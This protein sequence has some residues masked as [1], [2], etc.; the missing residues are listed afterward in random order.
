MADIKEKKKEYDKEYRKLNK[1]ML[2]GKAKTHYDSVRVLDFKKNP[3]KYLY[4]VAKS[5]AKQ[6][7]IE[8]SIDV[9]DITIPKFCPITEKELIKASGYAPNA[10]SL[11]RVDNERG[12]VKGNVRVISRE[13]NLKK[14]SLLEKDLVK[15]LSYV[16]GLL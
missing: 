9:T 8:F 2:S 10:M 15:L 5:R 14:S 13:A 7:N 16:R 4:K 1:E 11:D 3:E 12:Y 6:K